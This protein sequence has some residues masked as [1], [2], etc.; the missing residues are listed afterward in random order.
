[1]VTEGML[2]RHLTIFGKV[3]SDLRHARTIQAMMQ[4]LYSEQATEGQPT[5][6]RP[7]GAVEAFGLIL[8]EAIESPEGGGPEALRTGPRAFRPCFP[9]GG[10]EVLDLTIP[11]EELGITAN[12]LARLHTSAV[13]PPGAPRTGAEEA[14]RTRQRAA[15]IAAH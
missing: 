9:R 8:N 11:R 12:A 1:A 4:Q 13:R 2:Q 14:T 6:P 5:L 3:Y 7:L 10:G 15:L